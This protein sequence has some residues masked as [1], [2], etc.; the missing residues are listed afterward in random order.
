M[1]CYGYK[2]LELY[3]FVAPPKSWVLPTMHVRGVRHEERVC[4]E[5]V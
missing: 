5:N 3:N 2:D 4:V 1:H